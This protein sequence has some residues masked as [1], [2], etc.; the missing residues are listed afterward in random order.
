[1][2]AIVPEPDLVFF[3]SVVFV[4]IT[5]AGLV[6]AL[7]V[8]Y[9][10]LLKDKKSSKADGEK[11]SLDEIGKA[12][13]TANEIIKDAQLKAQEI[14][15]NS[16]T[17]SEETRKAFIK[18]IEIS[19]VQQAEA[20][21][22]IVEDAKSQTVEVLQ[23][24]TQDIKQQGIKELDAFTSGMQQQIQEAQVELKKSVSKGYA[25]VE[26]DIKGYKRM[27]IKQ[28]N[29]VIFEILKET[30]KRV[31][32]KTLSFKEHEDLVIKSLEEAKKE[33]VF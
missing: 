33:N 1:M 16:Q 18:E 13:D 14:I 3:Y 24:I 5:L 22:E 11:T 20:Y 26:E 9:T 25:Q 21:R 23:T 4:S 7:V 12:Q 8:L 2:P 10:K 17:F 29:E 32:G 6:V 31:L 28:V 19:Q 15:R 27:R 30:S